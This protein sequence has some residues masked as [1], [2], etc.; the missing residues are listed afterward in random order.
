MAWNFALDPVGED[1]AGQI[2]LGEIVETE[3]AIVVSFGSGGEGMEPATAGVAEDGIEGREA[4]EGFFHYMVQ[5]GR[6]GDVGR[7]INMGR[8]WNLP[9]TQRLLRRFFGLYVQQD[10][11]GAG[12]CK[13]PDHGLCDRTQRA[14]EQ[15]R[16]AGEIDIY[17]SVF[18]FIANQFPV[19]S[20]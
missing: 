9:V 5:R 17:H 19:L 7:E 14:R 6:V 18:C 2:H 20:F 15:D 13:L 1:G 8:R 10:E 3:N 4:L 16:F 11:G 12:R